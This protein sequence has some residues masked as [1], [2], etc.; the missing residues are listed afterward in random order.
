MKKCN[1]FKITFAAVVAIVIHGAARADD[2]SATS[3][4]Q[5][6]AA[7]GTVTREEG[8]FT[9]NNNTGAANFTL[10]LPSLPTRGQ[11]GPQINLTYNQFSGDNGNG[12]GIGWRFGISSIAFND[13]LG[14]AIP[15][16][17]PEGGFFS[18]LSYNGVRLI[19]QGNT[20]GVWEY[21]PEYAEDYSKILYHTGPFDVVSLNKTGALQTDTIPSG[22]EVQG[23]DGSRMIFSGDPAIAEGN[24]SSS[25]P[26]VAN[27]PL[28]LQL[29]ANREAVRYEYQK[30]GGRAYLK[31]ISFAGGQSTYSFDLIDTQATLVSHTTGATQRNAK[32]YGK[33]TARFNNTVYAQWCMGY[34]G[35]DTSNTTKFVV[36]AHPDCL[37]QAQA[38]LQP[39]IDANSFNVLDQLRVLYRYG[40]TGGAALAANT[41]KFPDVRFDYSSWTASELASR[42]VVFEAPK[43]AFAGDIPPQN[44]ELADLNMDGLTDIVQTKDDG[45]TV[46]LGGGDLSSAFS[47]TRQLLLSRPTDSG[48]VRQIAPRLTDDRFAFADLFGDSYVDIVEIGDG[49]MYIYDGHADG[50][51]PY[52]GRSIQV[53]GISPTSFAGGHGR[54]AD[55]NNDSLSDIVT[56]HLNADGKTEWQIFLNLTRRQPDGGYAVNFGAITKRF[57]FESNDGQILSR[58]NVRLVDVNGDR[59][60]DLVVIR[61]ADQGFCL[62]ENQ[63]NIFSTDPNALLFGDA[64]LNDRICGHGTFSKIGGMQPGDNLQTMWYIDANG[65]GIIDFASMG[66]RTDQ[67]KVWLGFGNGSYLSDP[68]N[69][70]LNLR[71]QVGT[72]SQTFS[73]RVADIDGDG[74][75]EIL[76]FQKPSGE[77]VKPVVVIDFNRTDTMQLVKANLL[78]SVDFAS[79]R[80]HDIRY[81]TSIDEMLRDRANGLSS[82]NLH[83]PVVVAKQIVTSQGVPGMARAQAQTEEY[84]YHNPYYD[85]INRRFIGFSDVEKVTYGDETVGTGRV[86]QRSGMTREQFY[87]FAEAAADLNLAGKLKIRKTYELKP[88]ATLLASADATLQFDPAMVTLHSL[89]TS[90]RSQKLPQTGAMLKCESS[91]WEAHPNGDGSSY[92]RKVKDTLVEQA[93]TAEQQDPADPECKDPVKTQ[94]YSEF[95]KY[96]IPAIETVQVRDIPGPQGLTVP[97]FTRT[98]ETD[99]AESRSALAALGIVNA[100]SQRRVLTGTRLLSR[101][102]Y[103]YL[104]D[105]GGRMGS[106]MLEVFSGLGTVPATLE[107]LK[108]P[109]RAL[110]KKMAYDVFGNVIAMSDDFG[111]TE[112]V[113]YEE[114][115][116]LPLRH[117]KLAGGTPELDQVTAMT[118]DGPRQ[119]AVNT[120]TT[121]LGMVVTQEYD[122]LGRKIREVAA[123]GAEKVFHYKIGENGLPSLILTSK[124]RYPNAAA[125]P[126]GETEWIDEMAAYNARGDKIADLENA[127]DG[128]VRVS[129]FLFYNRNEKETFRWTPF[130]VTSFGGVANLDLQATFGLGDIPRPDHEIGNAYTYDAAARMVHETH[131]SG[132]FSDSS[133]EPWGTIIKTTYTD[134]FAGTVT[135]SEYSLS[136]ENG[137][138]AVIASD[139]N[140]R[141]DITRFVRDS[142]GYLS[143]IWLPGETTPRRLT[144]NSVGDIEYQSLPGMGERYAFYDKRGRQSAVAR[145]GK[146]GETSVQTYTYDFLNRK[147]TEVNDGVLHLEYQYDRAVQ[148]AS[149]AGFEDGIPL[150]LDKTTQVT[151]HDPNGLLNAVE[152]YAY[153]KNGRMVTNEVEING[154]SY[155]DHFHQTLDGRIDSSVGPR[156]LA[157]KFALGP[158]K[159]LKSVTVMHSDFNGP[160]KVIENITYNAEG[161]IARVDYRQGAFTE[162]T[163]DPATLFMTKIVSKAGGMPLQDLSMTFNS[164]GSITEIVDAL[165]D[166]SGGPTHVDR[167]GTFHYD[168]KNQLVSF[169]RYGEQANFEYTP[170]G[171]FA[172]DDEFDARAPLVPVADTGLVPAST[173]AKRYGFDAFG[174]LANSPSLTGTVFDINGNL[175]RAQAAAKDVFYG[176]D[177]TGR[178]LYKKVVTTDGSAPDQLYLYP[179]E[180]FEVGPK[181][182]ESY[183]NIA[184]TKLVRLE[185]GTGKWFYYLKDHIESSDYV[186]ASDGTPVEQM[187]YRAY[188]T[189]H[190]PEVVAP[191]W[192]QH[193]TQVAAELPREKTHHRYTGKYLDD[194]TGLYYFG[195]RYYDP[196]LGRFISP[197]PLYVGDPER[198]TG[199]PVSCNLFAYA[200]NNPMAY[201]DPTG[202][203]EIVAGDAAYRRQVEEDM[204]RTDPTARVDSKT[205]EVSQSWLHGAW[206]DIKNFF[207]PGTSM[208]TGRELTKRIVDSPETVTIQNVPGRTGTVPTDLTKDPTTTPGGAIIKYDPAAARTRTSPEFDKATNTVSNNAADPGIVLAHEQIHASHIQSGQISGMGPATYK[209]LDGSTHTSMDE[210]ARTVGVGGTPRPDDITEN[211]LRD[212]LGI[213]PRNNYS[214]FHP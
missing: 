162:M 39:R 48:M 40:E 24:F 208:D 132:K 96:N 62:Y 47:E 189:E 175:I 66:D 84:Y 179:V 98:T 80:R 7:G 34:V 213:L 160:Q 191:A 198:C 151:I 170:A 29:N 33:V 11:F 45:A 13:D 158:D 5:L 192:G 177:Q 79:G 144:H 211:Q 1:L 209:G 60:P 76:V 159:N 100:G 67:M 36:R 61:P 146:N 70:Q 6:P 202:L 88:D 72:S 134:Q 165:R 19:F 15:G 68:I 82:H 30:F 138:T 152:R 120:M 140:G 23:A 187:L 110:T 99:Y 123:D 178:R 163:Y 130:V 91:I 9:L 136:N 139:G 161:R 103:V 155:A 17:R 197:D 185:H 78:T 89:S 206:L 145:I 156:G 55:L 28:V 141:N 203:K 186:I 124:R 25:K 90:T 41:L 122:A 2:K 50:S 101:E 71:V 127:A 143:E 153:N 207:V 126:Q 73:S 10:P 166:G 137:I 148:V 196:V 83:F 114:T 150:P 188:G 117:A 20:N 212:M 182:E 102:S 56:T 58:G 201:I 174:Q 112:A 77:D 42:P 85:V 4:V 74:Q 75:A 35:R 95:D 65:D 195:A 92:L 16:T 49:V 121:P 31:T 43:M 108:T 64:T 51:F 214:P 104:P 53:P 169:K 8:S 107:S 135:T 14:T 183:V 81:A 118:Y 116:T 106:R 129:N 12:L 190:Q 193:V 69:I 171:A 167:S 113:S 149:A 115:G 205:G 37:A 21:R 199:N 26:Y 128:G 18:H 54:F 181:G 157:S 46:Y 97:G 105:F 172:R 22:F 87:T 210:E 147:L 32:L 184:S 200:N 94:T 180:T 119:G 142:F 44:F 204:Q 86:T 59:L 111:Q 38:D 164:N 168:F 3:V 27:W 57:P 133:Y 154:A 63:G 93:G 125:T 194:D 109:V 173:A 176:Y 52:I 131:P